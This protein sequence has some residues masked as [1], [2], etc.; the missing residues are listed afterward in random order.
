MCAKMCSRRSLA[1]MRRRFSRR[2]G[3][4]RSRRTRSANA[5][6]RWRIGDGKEP[7]CCEVRRLPHAWGCARDRRR[8]DCGH[9][10]FG[11]RPTGLPP[12]T[13][14]VTR[15]CQFCVTRRR[16]RSKS[17]RG[18]P[19]SSSPRVGMRTIS[20][21]YRRIEARAARCRSRIIRCRIAGCGQGSSGTP[22]ACEAKR[23]DDFAGVSA[24]DL[25][26]LQSSPQ[27]EEMERFRRAGDQAGLGE[28]G[29]EIDALSEELCSPYNPHKLCNHLDA[30]S[31]VAC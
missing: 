31:R 14:G 1:C 15:L 20:N 9:A 8:E 13:Y 23:L 29:C 28:A 17:W 21:G 24:C 19:T 11:A 16:R 27:A 26:L 3:W 2:A 6:C 7:D 30:L 4:P 5:L 25:V 12:L 18:S 10:S 22:E